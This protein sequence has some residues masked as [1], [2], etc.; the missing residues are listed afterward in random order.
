MQG[1]VSEVARLRQAIEDE[2]VSL[3]RAFHD[4]SISASHSVIHHKYE[5][6]DQHREQLAQHIGD[7]QALNVMC[8]T[9]N[10]IVVGETP[11]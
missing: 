3:N 11:S 5:A 4:F 1:S 7:E 10:R 8:E 6:I 2:C 9:Y